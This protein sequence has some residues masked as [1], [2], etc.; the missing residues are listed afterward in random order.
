MQHE[1]CKGQSTMKT[2]SQQSCTVIRE[3][4][5]SPKLAYKTLTFMLVFTTGCDRVK[6]MWINWVL[7]LFSP[8]FLL[9]SFLGGL[10]VVSS[11]TCL[12]C[13]SHSQGKFCRLHTMS[14]TAT[15]LFVHNSHSEVCSWN[16]VFLSSVWV[17][18]VFLQILFFSLFFLHLHFTQIRS[19]ML[20]F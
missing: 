7:C 19:C 10:C 9:S 11:R 3:S 6:M 14:L 5:L 1:H 4:T 8:P 16:F 12:D 13:E 17:V 20:D 15:H 2:I 18:H